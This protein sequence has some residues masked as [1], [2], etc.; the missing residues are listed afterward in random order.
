MTSVA[1]A[2]CLAAA[3][4][5][6]GLSSQPSTTATSPSVSALEAHLVSCLASA[7]VPSD[8]TEEQVNSEAV[9]SVA[10]ECIGE[11]VEALVLSDG[12]EAA[13][14]AML[15]LTR[16]HPAFADC[17]EAA[18]YLA[19]G[20]AQVVPHEELMTYSR[21][22]CSYGYLDGA[23]MAIDEANAQ[24]D[25]SEVLDRVVES[26]RNYPRDG[27]DWEGVANNCY[28]G[29][30]HILWD[31]YGPHVQD[32]LDWCSRLS[33]DPAY[34]GAV[35]PSAQCVGGA[36]MSFAGSVLNPDQGVVPRYKTPG[37]YCAGLGPQEQIQCLTFTV[38]VE[39][40]A[41][42]NNV[43]SYLKW[44]TDPD[45]G[46]TVTEGCFASIAGQAGFFRNVKD[47]L[48]VCLELADGDRENEFACAQASV[49][50]IVATSQMTPDEAARKV[51]QDVPE[52]CDAIRRGAQVTQQE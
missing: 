18:H 5:W 9:R 6:A 51:C 20:A 45:S 25:T 48:P 23:V 26:C 39:L 21:P 42:N 8:L 38:N 32:T 12:P 52:S 17:H 31:R 47:F 10:T 22:Y 7:G 50:G 49:A 11:K 24:E 33:G 27:D 1:L 36:A 19:H 14:D 35:P 46:I 2:A 43:R 15:E 13:W 4:A 28:H 37:Q 41:R 44:C 3:L 29:V 30:G 34:N 40:Q 16:R